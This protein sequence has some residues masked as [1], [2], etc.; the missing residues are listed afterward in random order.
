M[1][2]LTHL[3]IVDSPTQLLKTDGSRI[4]VSAKDYINN[5]IPAEILDTPNL[6]VVN[7]CNDYRYLRTGYYCSLLAEARGHRCI[8]SASDLVH[9]NRRLI[10]KYSLPE[11]EA[12]LR[13]A[14]LPEDA[15]SGDDGLVFFFGRTDKPEL[16]RFGRKLFDLFRLPLMKVTFVRRNQQWKVKQVNPLRLGDLGEKISLFN[17]AISKYTGSFWN[18]PRHRNDKYWLAILHD[19]NEALAPSNKRALEKFVQVG[20]RKR[21]FVELITKNNLDSLLEYDALFIRETTSVANHTYRFAQKAERE[22]IPCIDDTTSILRCCNKIY[23]H[24]LL[25][26]KKI[27][28]P[29][30]YFLSRHQKAFDISDQFDFPVVLKVPDGSFS[31]GVFKVNSVEEFNQKKEEIFKD[32]ELLIVQEFFPSAYDWRIVLIGGQPLFACKYY[33]AKKH[34]QIYNHQAKRGKEGD[35]ECVPLDKVPTA[36]LRTAT[37]AAGLIGKGLY[38]VD[39]KEVDK[40]AYVIEINDNPNIDAGVEDKVLG[41]KLYETVLDHFQQLIDTP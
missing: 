24:E 40:K 3:I 17:D 28:T 27:R 33:M 14:K 37:R 35:A 13:D 18:R 32:S 10:H 12:I 20:R 36:V 31:K 34:W 30:T 25:R 23:L 7:L 26:G 15:L 1:A 21:F 2:V 16:L 6:R 41:D 5:D 9:T 19:P 4:V 39:I 38:G 11:L 8:P 29:R 22:G